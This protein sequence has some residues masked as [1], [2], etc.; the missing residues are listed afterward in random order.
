M[1]L[2][3]ASDGIADGIAWGADEGSPQCECVNQYSIYMHIFKHLLN[4]RVQLSCA[5]L[6]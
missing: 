1:K 6:L 3:Q 5:S 2:G 4:S